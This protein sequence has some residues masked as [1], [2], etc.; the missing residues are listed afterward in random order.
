MERNFF[1]KDINNIQ[2]IKHE[3]VLKQVRNFILNLRGGTILLI[4]SMLNKI[5]YSI[6]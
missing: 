5:K 4:L 3:F 6:N 1:P 2:N